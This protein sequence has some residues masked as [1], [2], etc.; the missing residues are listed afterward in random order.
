MENFLPLLGYVAMGL[1]LIT[2]EKQLAIDRCEDPLDWRAEVIK[3]TGIHA[4]YL[5]YAEEAISWAIYCVE[6]PQNLTPEEREQRFDIEHMLSSIMHSPSPITDISFLGED[7]TVHDYEH[8]RCSRAIP[9]HCTQSQG[10]QIALRSLRRWT[11]E[12]ENFFARLTEIQQMGCR[13]PRLA[14]GTKTPSLRFAST[15]PPPSALNLP[16]LLPLLNMTSPSAPAVLAAPFPPLPLNSQQKKGKTI[17]RR[18]SRA[19]HAQKG[20]VP[21]KA[22]VFPLGK[23]G[24]ALYPPTSTAREFADLWEEYPGPQCRFDP[25]H[26]QWDLCE[27]FASNDPV[28]GEGFAQAPDSDNEIDPADATFPPKHR[29]GRPCTASKNCVSLIFLKFW[30][31]APN[32]VAKYEPVAA[33]LLDALYKRFGFTMPPSPDRFNDI[34]NQLASDKALQNILCTF[35]GA[36]SEKRV[37]STTSD[38]ALLDYHQPSAPQGSTHGIQRM[39]L[40]VLAEDG[41][42]IGSEVLLLPRAHRSPRGPPSAVGSGYQGNHKHLL[43]RGIPF[44]LAYRSLQ[45]MPESTPSLAGLR[46]KGFKADTASGLGFR[47]HGYKFDQ[48]DYRVYTTWRDFQLLHTP[49]RRI[50]LQYGQKKGKGQEKADTNQAG[51]VSWWP[52]PNAWA[53]EISMGRGGR[54]NRLGHLANGVFLLPRQSQW[55]SNLKFQKEVKKCWD[56]VEIVSDS[57]VQGLVAAL[58]AA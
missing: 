10:A 8:A 27:L 3:N 26:N 5:E 53:R 49:R 21:S 15:A 48:H 51:I 43:A 2:I 34:A 25:F 16:R 31:G 41:S 19:E 39:L 30:Y 50:A 47:P 57:I 54:H 14:N 6:S 37:P 17:Q 20:G 45:I 38:K 1:W 36:V 52:K 32:E 13:T 35:F 29:H 56:G 46:P 28:F 11:R 55:R 7:P 24:W 44:W 22:T 42:G 33:N 40:Y 4:S 23:S 58:R 18:T 12:Q 9:G